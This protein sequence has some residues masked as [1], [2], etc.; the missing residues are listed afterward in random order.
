MAR[1]C[2]KDR[3]EIAKMR[4][5]KVLTGSHI[6]RFA[7][8]LSCGVLLSC[9]SGPEGVRKKEVRRDWFYPTRK[10]AP[11]PIYNRLRDV[12]PP[13]PI[14]DPPRGIERAPRLFP[15]IQINLR[16]AKLSE[17]ARILAQSYRYGHYCSPLLAEKRVSVRAIGTLNELADEVARL[18][19][20]RVAVDHEN[21]E[22]RI[23]SG[24]RS[25]Q[26][27]PTPEPTAPERKPETGELRQANQPPIRKANR[28]PER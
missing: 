7:L 16:G 24:I 18:G 4:G 15:I 1:G 2:T 25:R 6:R 28:P 17:V 12:R 26:I 22:V 10:Q 14:P 23:L 8:A 27:E 13:E 9:S 19:S 21:R 3:R 5:R 11:E 20:V